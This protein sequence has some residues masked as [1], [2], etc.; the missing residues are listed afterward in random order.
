MMAAF[1]FHADRTRWFVP[2]RAGLALGHEFLLR[3]RNEIRIFAMRGDDHAELL[4]K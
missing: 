4:G 1:S 3:F 2:L